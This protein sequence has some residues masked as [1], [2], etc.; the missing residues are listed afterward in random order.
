MDGELG[1]TALLRM[2]DNLTSS[3]G[4]ELYMSLSCDGAAPMPRLHWRLGH[5]RAGALAFQLAW[6]ALTLQA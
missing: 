1:I 4:L 3:N 6:A 2:P 5:V